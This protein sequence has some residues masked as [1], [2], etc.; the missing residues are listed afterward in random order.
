MKRPT[1]TPSSNHFNGRLEYLKD[2]NKF[3]FRK[4]Q[5]ISDDM[6]W[7]CFPPQIWLGLGVSIICVIAVLNFMQRA[8]SYLIPENGD[9]RSQSGRKLASPIDGNPST[10]KTTNKGRRRVKKE[11]AKQF[12]YVFGN[13]L[14]QGQIEILK[15]NLTISQPINY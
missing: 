4:C 10:N 12:L 7:F 14:S 5:K 9:Y 11:T 8:L 2:I 13:L 1:S 6:N 15:L 3:V